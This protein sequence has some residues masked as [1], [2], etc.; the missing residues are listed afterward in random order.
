MNLCKLLPLLTALLLTGCQEDFMDLHFE[1]AV[2][3]RGRQVYTRVSTLLEE[4]LRAH[5]IAAEKIEL[6][7]DAQDPRVIHLAINGE[8]PPE[9]RAALRAVFDD[10]LKARAASS[11]VIVEGIALSGWIGLPTFNRSQPDLQYWFVNGRSVT[12]KTLAHA[13]RADHGIQTPFQIGHVLFQH[14]CIY[15]TLEIDL[16]ARQQELSESVGDAEGFSALVAAVNRTRSPK[17]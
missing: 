17:S 4:A 1:Q 11:M 3:D 14:C 6:E 2:G 8:L 7:L 12:D 13:A 10:I 9:Q 16:I 5:G 15:G